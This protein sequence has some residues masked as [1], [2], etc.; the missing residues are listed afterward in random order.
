[1][2]GAFDLF[3]IGH[4]EFLKKAKEMGDYL[5]VGVHDDA[6][7]CSI[8]EPNYPIMNVHERVLSVLACKVCSTV[9]WSTVIYLQFFFLPLVCG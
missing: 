4:I 9:L 8:R 3:H 5:L 2:E 1:M 7:V 6:T